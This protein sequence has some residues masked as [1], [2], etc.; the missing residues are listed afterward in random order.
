MKK[1]LSILL[2]LTLSLGLASA[3]L[4]EKI[5]VIGQQLG[6][7]VFLPAEVGMRDAGE[8]LGIEV[9]WQSPLR[10]EAELQN[11]IMLSLID[12]G[13]VDGIA[14]SATTGDALKDA[15]DAAIDAGI[16]VISYDVDSP[17]SKREYYVGTENYKV[18]YQAGEYMIDLYK[19]S[20]LEKVR[21][22]QLEGIPGANDIEARK[23]GFAD[24]IKGTNLEVVYSL[25]CNDN[26]DEAINGIEYYTAANAENIDA[27]Y[28]AGGWPYSV[29]P[30]AL[31]E[32]NAWKLSDPNHKVV[33][34]DIFAETTPG[35]FELGVL[36]VAIGQDFYQM[37]YQ[38]VMTLHKLINGLEVDAPYNEDI[39][40]KF[41]ATGGQIATLENW[42]EVLGVD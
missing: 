26:V 9:E 29:D 4:A 19:D 31:P 21:V 20:G 11:E 32:M 10:A 6:N 40:A 38:C 15:I 35:F 17:N 14:I 42:K 30:S 23:L 41:I 36:D 37:G 2:I 1:L 13:D 5:V 24:A 8:E 25:P 34:I 39:G 16:K 22:V 27:W 3:A 7:V 28:M 12:R 33:T 18:G